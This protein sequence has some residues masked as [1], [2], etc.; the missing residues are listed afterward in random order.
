MK[1]KLHLEAQWDPHSS[2]KCHEDKRET[3]QAIHVSNDNDTIK[4]IL[5]YRTFNSRSFLFPVKMTEATSLIY[6]TGEIICL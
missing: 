5:K 2:H 3:I 4:N 1:R 6:G